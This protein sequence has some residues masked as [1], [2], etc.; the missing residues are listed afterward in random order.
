LTGGSSYIVYPSQPKEYSKKYRTTI[1]FIKDNIQMRATIINPCYKRDYEFFHL[2]TIAIA[3]AINASPRHQASVIDFSFVWNQWEEFLQ[4]KLLEFQPQLI[5]ISTASPL[6]PQAL[7]IAQ[8]CMQI[9]PGVKI[10]MG[11]HH[12]SL[13]T[14]ETLKQN[15]VDFVVVGEGENTILQLLDTMEDSPGEGYQSIPFLAFKQDGQLFENPLGMLPSNV[16][17]NQ[18]PFNDWF[19]WPEHKRAIYHCGFLPIIG[20]RGCPYRCSFCSSPVLADRL[21]NCGP[22]VRQKSAKLVAREIAWQWTRHRDH[23]LRYIMFYDQNFLLSKTWLQ[24]FCEEYLDLGMHQKLPFSCYSRLDHLSKEKLELARE[25]GCIQIRVGIESGNPSIREKLLNK[26]LSQK[27]LIEKMK[28]LNASK[29][30][31]L[32]YFLIGSPGENITQA[33]ESFRIAKEVQLTRSAFFFFTPLHNL[34]LQEKVRID[35]L[36]QENSSGFAFADNITEEISGLSRW[37]LLFLFY[38]SNGWFLL[39]TI[40]AQLKGQGISYLYRF[41]RYY[42]KARSDGFD[43]KQALLQYT[44]YHGDSFLY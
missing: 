26:Q 29:I 40:L 14:L 15:C 37:V 1:N 11:G 2:G 16:E 23:G 42:W 21:T 38:R 41:P 35:Y 13:D 28:L 32:G 34:P 39:K 24:E 8:R 10:A 20:V 44:Y 18:F 7:T 4:R 31:S 43:F 12:A 30:N 22:F 36:N 6:M 17:L 25:A 3:S 27:M 5:G 9:L 19:L 33:N